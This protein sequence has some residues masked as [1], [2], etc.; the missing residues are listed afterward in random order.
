MDL[1]SQWGREP[2]TI[3]MDDLRGDQGEA[4]YGVCYHITFRIGV[5]SREWSV[6]ARGRNAESGMPQLPP[7]GKAASR[8]LRP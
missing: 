3:N 5:D 6:I 4:A 1:A 2:T 7:S 8:Q